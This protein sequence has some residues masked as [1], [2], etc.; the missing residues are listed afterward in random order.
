MSWFR[1]SLMYNDSYYTAITPEEYYE[2]KFTETIPKGTLLSRD[3][4]SSHIFNK[5]LVV[6]STASQVPDDCLV[7]SKKDMRLIKDTRAEILF[8]VG[9]ILSPKELIDKH[10][11]LSDKFRANLHSFQLHLIN[12]KYITGGSKKHNLYRL[13][14][15]NDTSVSMA[16]FGEL[17]EVL[18]RLAVVQVKLGDAANTKSGRAYEMADSMR[19]DKIM[20]LLR[21]RHMPT[22][23]VSMDFLLRTANIKS[24]HTKDISWSDCF[25]EISPEALSLKDRLDGFRNLK[26]VQSTQ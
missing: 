13:A 12:K 1:K 21:Q 18:E 4:P 15:H 26:W 16:S 25:T 24:T 8:N 22:D 5:G 14:D 20:N 6:V 9:Q 11:R 10:E 7:K 3:L 23:S 2:W 19:F 17:T